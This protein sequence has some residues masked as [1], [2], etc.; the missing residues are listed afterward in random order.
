MVKP[1]VLQR[2]IVRLLSGQLFPECIPFTLIAVIMNPRLRNGVF[3]IMFGQMENF[4]LI[5]R[6][7]LH[8]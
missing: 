6:L 7:T 3:M 5:D 4:K 1:N 2:F 8:K